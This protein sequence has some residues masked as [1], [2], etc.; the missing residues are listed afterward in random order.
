MIV[1]DDEST[2][3]AC[4]ESIK[5]HVDE[6]VVVDT[7]STDASPTIAQEFAD[8]W[9]S[10]NGCNDDSGL[11]ADFADAR[12][13]SFSLASH[14]W[15]CWFDGDD[16][17]QGGEGMRALAEKGAEDVVRYIVPY[18]YGHDAEGR[19]TLLQ[20]RERLMRPRH[21]LEWVSPVH[22][23]CMP[24]N[25]V[26]GTM[27]DH[28]SDAFRVIHRREKSKKRQEPHRNL[29]I[30]K[31]Y[32]GNVGE[33]DTRAIYYLGFEFAAAGD[34]GS[35]I[36]YLRRYTEIGTH[37]DHRCKA[38]L[39]LAEIYRGIG[40]HEQA[41]EWAMKAV[42]ERSW[43]EPYFSLC[44]SYYALAFK[45]G[46]EDKG[47]LH[48]HN[49]RKAAHFGQTGLTL[50]QDVIL[51]ADPMER[52]AIHEYLNVCFA[53]L[54]MMDEAIASCRA[55]LQGFPEHPGMRQNLDEHLATQHRRR[56]LDSATALR[57]MGRLE[58]AAEG[59]IRAALDGQLTLSMSGR[60]EPPAPA[61]PE[62][63]RKLAAPGKL[64][65]VF[66]VGHGVEPW[67]PETFEK[68]GMGGSETMAWEMAR[69][70][71]G[72]GH[73]VRLYGHCT[74]SMEGTFEG[75]TFLDAS[76]YRD[77]ECDVLIASRYPHAVDDSYQVRATARILWVHDVNCGEALT[78]ERALRF[79][80]ILCLSEWHAGFFKSCYHLTNP[81][82]VQVRLLRLL[83]LGE[84]GAGDER[85]GPAAKHRPP[86]AAH[87]VDGGCLHA[88]P[89]EPEGARPR[90]HA[91][92]G[93]GLPDMV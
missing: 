30:L 57:E 64:E 89:G 52:H 43:P 70:L 67:N 4:L 22:E 86:E 53:R 66:Y 85:E 45:L 90:V 71:A 7:G 25:P 80:R 42:G 49:L 91:L 26:E 48:E 74:P 46:E 27:A 10:Y 63:S 24:M 23:T 62:P 77:I 34:K 68:V 82:I 73:G 6:L 12:N 1:R 31:K 41:I 79:D 15:V 18:E 72:L 11:I 3:R 33:A 50:P 81:G 28:L 60:E 14:D 55:G 54:G 59:L 32:V 58:D 51:F 37:P 9:E 88:R 16:V 29:R 69:R 87:Q 38:F 84:R 40:D 65:L 20:Y 2:L 76:R 56:L 8:V 17:L 61:T 75:V 36:R 93:L 35:A 5:P 44:R 92:G 21:R 39:A 19:V 83:Q 78:Y 47:P 13:H